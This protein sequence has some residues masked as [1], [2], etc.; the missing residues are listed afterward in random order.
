VAM[1]AEKEDRD[2]GRAPCVARRPTAYEQAGQEHGRAIPRKCVSHSSP[3]TL[4]TFVD[5]Y[6][7]LRQIASAKGVEFRHL[8]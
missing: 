3:E 5:G 1:V 8:S 6:P 4:F 7:S 2:M